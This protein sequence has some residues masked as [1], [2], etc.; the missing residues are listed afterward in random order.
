MG[1]GRAILENR[2]HQRAGVRCQ[3]EY[4]VS[5]FPP[6]CSAGAEI[7]A[8]DG[9]DHTIEFVVVGL[10]KASQ[11]ACPVHQTGS[12]ERKHVLRLRDFFR[13]DMWEMGKMS[14]NAKAVGV[15]GGLKSLRAKFSERRS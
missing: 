10:N 1:V 12:I 13:R 2:R 11:H 8:P 14:F 6:V 5:H 7:I 4:G 3:P 15:L 9:E